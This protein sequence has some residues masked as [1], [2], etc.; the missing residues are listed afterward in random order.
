MKKITIISAL[1]A[2]LFSLAACNDTPVEFDGTEG[3][4]DLSFNLP[5]ATRADAQGNESNVEEVQMLLFNADEELYKY[6]QLTTAEISSRSALFDHILA[7]SYSMYIVAN[8]P[9]LSGCSSLDEMVE[10]GIN[11]DQYNSTTSTFVMEGHCNVTVTGGSTSDADISLSRYVSRIV[12][13]KV[14]NNLPE[15]YGNFT[16]TRA[17]VANAICEQNLGGSLD[18]GDD[19]DNWY[20]KEG[21]MDEDER[22]A[23][24]IIN[25][26]AYTA[27]APNLTFAAIGQEIANNGN[28]ASAKYFY[29][30]PN[31]STTAPNGFHDTFTA[32]KTVLVIEGS[33][34]GHTYYYP[35][36]MSGNLAR[37]TSYEV[38]ATITGAG[39]NDP[40]V[41]VQNGSISL[42]ITVENWLDGTSY[43]ET[44]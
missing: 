26:T 29:A 20:N 17:Y 27:S 37:N 16:L 23:S 44:F 10:T 11:L 8:G 14:I 36:V 9:D 6:Y 19:V 28:Y 7:G 24:H 38:T 18:C 5:Q 31:N 41:P 39:S 25:G 42:T 40:V 32:Q 35:V 33:F 3:S 4:I 13:K 34:G 43:T 12:L 2:G 15:A 22:V 30:Y 21:R 1:A